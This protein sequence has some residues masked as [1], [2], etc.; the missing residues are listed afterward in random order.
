[1]FLNDAYVVY[2]GFLL[3]DVNQFELPSLAVMSTSC[4]SSG[5]DML[6]SKVVVK[7][8][9]F[10]YGMD[11]KCYDVLLLRYIHVLAAS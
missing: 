6:S 10:I 3:Q 1:M 2:L 11:T 9:E 8:L 7:F 5:N 4:S